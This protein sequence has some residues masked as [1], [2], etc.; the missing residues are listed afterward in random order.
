MSK[1]HHGC[2]GKPKVMMESKFSSAYSS[3]W[4]LYGDYEQPATDFL[5]WLPIITPSQEEM[6]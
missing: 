4:I 3:G 5:C 1:I 6:R 2:T